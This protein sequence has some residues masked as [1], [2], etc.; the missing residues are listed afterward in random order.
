MRICHI[1]GNDDLAKVFVGELSDGARIEFVESIQPPVPREEKWVLIVSTL[2]GCP[3]GCPICDAGGSYAGPLSADEIL[4][5]IDH[6]ISSRYPSGPV[7][8]P[9]LKIQFARMGD[10]ALNDAVLDVLEAL[11]HRY[12][13]PGLMPCISTIAPAGR[14]DFFEK[15]I[16]I[17]N[18]HYPNGRFQMQFSL[19]TTDE[20]AK[21]KLIPARTWTFAEMAAW[22]TR[23][24]R[25][26]DR[27]ITLNFAPAEGLPLDPAALLPHFNPNTTYI[28]LTPI[29]PTRSATR[30]N[31]QG[32]L[33]PNDPEACE[34]IAD[35]FRRLG[36]ETLL[37]IGELEENQIGSN[38][39]MYIS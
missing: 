24:H 37:S 36:F 3:I 27:K 26:G 14:M 33:D 20:T 35:S 21:R 39:G 13:A 5:Q 34:K 9:K 32:L 30:A 2:R 17:K 6:L 1:T 38:C 11:P 7:P 28:K 12:S 8:I 29:N 31:L 16:D 18:T 15:L 23:F 25:P 19:H 10:P 22:S 4:G